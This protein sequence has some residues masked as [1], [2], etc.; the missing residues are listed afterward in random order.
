MKQN[1]N[2]L[3]DFINEISL[4]ETKNKNDDEDYVSLMTI[5]QSKGLEFPHIYIVGLENGLF[6]SQ[7]NMREK[8]MLEE[9]RRLFYVAITR[10]IKKVTLSYALSRFQFGIMNKTNKSLFLDEINYFFIEKTQRNYQNIKDVKNLKIPKLNNR[11]LRKITTNTNNKYS[12]KGLKIGQHILHNIFGKGEI[13]KIDEN[14]G[15]QKITVFFEKG[16][17]KILLTKF[18]KI[19]ILT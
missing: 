1:N 8:K 3:I 15:N 4:D 9:E 5:H 6:P 14:D 11:K 18:A 17:E 16:G 7:K 10:A 19:K 13:K 12:I 2:K